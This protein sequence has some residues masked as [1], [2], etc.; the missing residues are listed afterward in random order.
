MYIKSTYDVI[1]EKTNMF[2]RMRPAQLAAVNSICSF[3][4]IGKEEFISGNSLRTPK[5]LPENLGKEV[6]D[7]RAQNS[8]LFFFFESVLDKLPLQGGDGLKHKTGLDEY[9]YDYVPS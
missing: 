8:E 3:G 7:F 2:R 4:Y 5:E 1:P 6:M 9:R